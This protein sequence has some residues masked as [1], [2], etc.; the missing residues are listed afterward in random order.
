M[1]GRTE[2]NYTDDLRKRLVPFCEKHHIHRLE[3]I[4]SAARGQAGPGSDLDLLAT[5]DESVPSLQQRY[6]KWRERRRS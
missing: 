1:E 2:V 4:G 5:L 3:I 6:W